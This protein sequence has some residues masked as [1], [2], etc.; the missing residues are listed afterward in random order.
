VGAATAPVA[1]K[2]ATPP[3]TRGRI[4]AFLLATT[5]QSFRDLQA[6]YMQIGTLY[7]T[8]LACRDN[9]QIT[10][11]DDPLVT[12]WAQLRAIKVL[13]RFD[14][15]SATRLHA[16]LT[17]QA[18]RS[19]TLS[20]LTGLVAQQ[21][22]DGIN[23]DFESGL[24]T[25]RDALTRFAASLASRLHA[26]G[27]RLTVEVS[28]KSSDTTTGRSGFY[29]YEALGRVVDTVFVMNWGLHW[30]TSGPGA[31]DELP[32]ATGVADYVA[33]MRDPSRFVLGT[34]LYGIDWESGGGSAHPGVPLEYADVQDLI[35][36]T[37]S[38][39]A[40]DPVAYAPHF[41]YVDAQGDPH[42]VWYTDARSISARIQLARQRG[43]G[44]GLWRLGR[45]DQALWANPLLA[46]GTAWP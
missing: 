19:A 4:H 20:R 27:K 26:A 28:A 23:L 15:Q 10:G 5:D 32:W 8:Y 6:H 40:F 25:D 46:P 29:D 7:P 35:A 43:L 42:E 21:G 3:P 9:G 22:W 37:G 14:C 13:P 24:A 11:R 18:T 38:V 30:S 16:M 2:T 17:D 39:P 44:V 45:E 12:R 36:R 41:S 31:T 34:N 33:S 1:V